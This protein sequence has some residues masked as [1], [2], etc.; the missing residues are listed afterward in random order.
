MQGVSLLNRAVFTQPAA[1]PATDVRSYFFNEAEKALRHA[2]DVS[3]QRLHV[4]H[5]QLA[6]LYEKRG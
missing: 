1:P 3:G 6:R 2:Y 5:L 4:V